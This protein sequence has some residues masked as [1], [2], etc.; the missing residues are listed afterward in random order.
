VVKLGFKYLRLTGMQTMANAQLD[1]LDS[2]I[3][4]TPTNEF[5]ERLDRTLTKN[6]LKR[7][8]QRYIAQ[9]RDV[10]PVQGEFAAHVIDLPICSARNWAVPVCAGDALSVLGCRTPA[11][12]ATATCH[13]K[14]DFKLFE[15]DVLANWSVLYLC[16]I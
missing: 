1:L 4:V 14:P 10:H 3:E 2:F 6:P 15:I 9:L 13:S 12:K 5:L 7:R 16:N 11:G 8:Y